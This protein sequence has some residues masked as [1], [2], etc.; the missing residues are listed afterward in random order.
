MTLQFTCINAMNI[1]HNDD[2]VYKCANLNYSKELYF[3][4]LV[5]TG[6]IISILIYYSICI[7]LY[8]NFSVWH[9]QEFSQ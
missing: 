5:L 8:F 6:Y 7:I 3:T 2:N 4:Y 9:A 1:M